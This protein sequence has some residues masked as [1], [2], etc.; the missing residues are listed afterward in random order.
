MRAG[1]RESQEAF[2]ARAG[3]T[4]DVVAGIEDGTRPAWSLAGP[5]ALA[6]E[7]AT[8]VLNPD[9]CRVFNVA[10]WCDLYLTSLVTRDEIAAEGALIV[11]QAENPDLAWSLLSWAVT[12]I[13]EDPAAG[14]LKA[15]SGAPL[16]PV[17]VLAKLAALYLPVLIYGRSWPSRVA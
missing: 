14:H 2:A 12:G 15:S 3:V 8:G 9:L 13:L 17:E 4:V 5:E 16:L 6:V 10:A 7:A 1:Y 11:L